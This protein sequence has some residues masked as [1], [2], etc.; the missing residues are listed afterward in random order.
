MVACFIR[1]SINPPLAKEQPLKLSPVSREG[2]ILRRALRGTDSRYA[3]K[4]DLSTGN[5]RKPPLFYTHDEW[6]LL[7]CGTNT[8]TLKTTVMR[9]PKIYPTYQDI[10]RIDGYP[11]GQR[12]DNYDYLCIQLPRTRF[13]GVKECPINS[14]NQVFLAEY[15]TYALISC[16]VDQFDLALAKWEIDNKMY[17]YREYAEDKMLIRRR[18][19]IIYRFCEA[20][21]I[22]VCR[23]ET[24]LA[25]LRKKLSRLLGA[26]RKYRESGTVFDMTYTDSQEHPI[27][28]Q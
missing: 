2:Y 21:D 25:A 6:V 27:K 18:T 14:D 3:D 10:R 11:V 13:D 23:D 17:C 28:L 5:V 1:N 15:Y 22:P 16:F 24:E 20:Y 9:N 7:C 12:S 26:N 4:T 19:D 8:R